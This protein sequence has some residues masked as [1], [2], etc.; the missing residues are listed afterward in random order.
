MHDGD[1]LA[2]IADRVIEGEFGDPPRALPCVHAGRNGHRVRVVADRDVVLER[3]VKSLQV[4]AYH[5]EVD[6]LI[7][8]AGH[9]GPGRAK[10]GVKLEFLAQ[11]HVHRAEAAADRSGQRPFQREPGAA[12]AVQRRRRKRVGE[13]P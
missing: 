9:Q 8:S 10:V 7:A 13:R 5:D 2:A 6:V 3:D 12:D 11:P 4:L 1:L